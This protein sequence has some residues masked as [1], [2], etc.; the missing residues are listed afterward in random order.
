MHC[1]IAAPVL[2]GSCDAFNRAAQA[3]EPAAKPKIERTQSAEQRAI[4]ILVIRALTKLLTGQVA[5][6]V[7]IDDMAVYGA[8]RAMILSATST[9]DDTMAN[10]TVEGKIKVEDTKVEDTGGA[11]FFVNVRVSDRFIQKYGICLN[12][13]GAPRFLKSIMLRGAQTQ[14]FQRYYHF[15]LDSD[16]ITDTLRAAHSNRLFWLVN[17]GGQQQRL[18]AR[19]VA[20][21]VDRPTHAPVNPPGLSGAPEPIQTGPIAFIKRLCAELFS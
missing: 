9:C 8:Q 3:G 7:C 5:D 19:E 17:S 11:D 12:A 20:G 13:S 15:E 14:F 1:P 6:V 10:L 2:K 21:T 4:E 16:D 18:L